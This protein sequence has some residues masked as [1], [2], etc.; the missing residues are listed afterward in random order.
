VNLENL[1]D[2][3]I[4]FFI[5]GV[6]AGIVRTDVRLPE[7]IY[8]ILSIYLLLA[9]GLKGGVQLAMSEWST[10]FVPVLGAVALGLVIP[11]IAYAIL[12]RIGRLA[13]PDAAAVAAHYGSVSAVTYAVALAF[14]DGLGVSYE[15]YT[16]VLLVLLEIPAIAVGILIA[17]LR[18][19]T[20][21]LSYAALAH[22]VFFG[23]S[24]YLLIA[25]LIVGTIVGPEGI[26]PVRMVFIDP[27]KG[28][29]AFFLLEMGLVTSHRLSDLKRVGL[30]LAVFAVLMPVLSAAL[31]TVV[32]W[33]VGLSVGGTAVLATLAGS[34]SYIAAPAAMRIAVPEANPTLYLTAAL[35]VT[36]PFNLIAGIPL[37]Y[38][39]ATLIH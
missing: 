33:S 35:G 36:F 3:T 12:R 13:R 11:V 38:W 34:A 5:V 14:L 16:T 1:V 18:T 30:F 27:F 25:G 29:L 37:Y 8:E 9:I 23:K 26:E 19:A 24:I 17:R 20:G 10:L 4:L 32:G 6:L 39:M 2:P 21:T 15:G 22:E 31:G 28:A 7:A